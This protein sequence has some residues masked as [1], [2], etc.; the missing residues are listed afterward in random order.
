MYANNPVLFLFQIV[1]TLVVLQAGKQL[2]IITFDDISVENIKKVSS[3]VDNVISIQLYLQVFPLPLL[4]IGN[5]LF[6][7]GGTQKIR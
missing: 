7:L 2:N 6:G 5:L 4:Y 3:L 1:A